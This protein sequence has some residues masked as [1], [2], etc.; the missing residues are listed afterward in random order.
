MDVNVTVYTMDVNSLNLNSPEEI[1]EAAESFLLTNIINQA[2]E[3]INN[4]SLTGFYVDGNISKNLCNRLKECA[5]VLI[6]KSN[7][8]VFRARQFDESDSFNNMDN[9]I[10][11][12]PLKSVKKLWEIVDN[13]ILEFIIKTAKEEIVAGS[14]N[15]F[16][17]DCVI[18]EYVQNKLSECA[19]GLAFELLEEST[20]ISFKNLP[21]DKT[22]SIKPWYSK[23]FPQLFY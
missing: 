7:H 22:P 18:S 5:P 14:L 17:V 19:S 9:M 1:W 8:I 6:C 13:N 21:R 10:C 4:G 3:R 12:D 16:S 23:M 15:S 20:W 2:K 11:N